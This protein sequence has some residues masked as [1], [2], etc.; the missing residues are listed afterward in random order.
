MKKRVLIFSTLWVASIITTAFVTYYITFQQNS[1]RKI[2]VNMPVGV[3]LKEM[4]SKSETTYVLSDGRVVHE[5]ID[6]SET[7]DD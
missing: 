3:K 7:Y 4:H 6:S 5:T 2:G 1:E